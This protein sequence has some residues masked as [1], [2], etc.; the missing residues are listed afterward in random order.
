MHACDEPFGNFLAHLTPIA[1][2]A[3]GESLY[4]E[5]YWGGDSC[6]WFPNFSQ[7]LIFNLTTGVSS[8]YHERAALYKISPDLS[9]L[10]IIESSYRNPP[11]VIIRD[12]HDETQF[13]FTLT[14]QFLEAG[15]LTWSPDGAL[16]AFIAVDVDAICGGP[17]SFSVMLIEVATRHRFTII[18]EYKHPLHIATWRDGYVLELIDDAN[19][20]VIQYSFPDRQ[21]VTTPVHY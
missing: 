11:V 2:S 7:L 6:A 10:A 12:L 17:N 9:K 20:D 19:Q 18:K 14:P 16:I 15:D 4:A 5:F 8:I 3:D 1:W 21:I 13:S